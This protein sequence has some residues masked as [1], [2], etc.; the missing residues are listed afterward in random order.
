MMR[1]MVTS[2]LENGQ[3]KC[4][5]SRAKEVRIP[6]EKMITLAKKGDLHSRRQALSFVKTKEAMQILFNDLNKRYIN[7]NGGYSR[8]IKLGKTR[9]GDNADMAIIQLVESDKDNFNLKKKNIKK[10]NDSRKENKTL[11]QV[12]KDINTQ[13][14][15][16][17]DNNT[18]KSVE[19]KKNEEDINNSKE[20]NPKSNEIKKNEVKNK[21]L[22]NK[23]K[24][25]SSNEK[26]TEFNNNLKTQKSDFKTKKK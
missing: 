12:N 16:S 21:N 3:V 23:N 6:L 25:L 10:K 1:N 20:L 26:N 14:L 7:R 9:L 5:L 24:N 11:K 13:K 15:K 2:I 19:I 4:T 18:K 22:S 17:L 8:I